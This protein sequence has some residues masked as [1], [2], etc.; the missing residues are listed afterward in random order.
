MGATGL[1][2]HPNFSRLSSFG[3]GGFMTDFKTD[4]PRN[5]YI[6]SGRHS[7]RTILLAVAVFSSAHAADP[8]SIGFTSA[9][10][11]TYGN[12]AVWKIPAPSG[13]QM[14]IKATPGVFAQTQTVTLAWKGFEGTD[15]VFPTPPPGPN[16][17]QLDA[18]GQAIVPIVF[19]KKS[20][21]QWQ[22]TACAK[23]QPPGYDHK[24]D[25]CVYA[26]LEGVDP[27]QINAGKL[28]KIV[29]PAHPGL[30]HNWVKIP[31]HG[32]S[33]GVSVHD[34]ALAKSKDKVVQLVYYSSSTTTQKGNPWP[35][36]VEK[37]S[38]KTLS[39]SDVAGQGGW[40]QKSEPLV[41]DPKMG[42]WLTI[43]ACLNIEYSGKVCSDSYA[44]Q[45][46]KP[47]LKKGSDTNQVIDSSKIPPPLPPQ[48]G[49]GGGGQAGR[50]GNLP[51]GNAGMMAPPPVLGAPAASPPLPATNAHRVQ[52]ASPAMAPAVVPP[53]M[54]SG[55]MAPAA[56]VPGCAVDPAVPGRYA[57]AT[58]EAYAGCERLRGS[59][60][61]GVSACLNRGGRLRR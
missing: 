21:K 25:D 52:P 38:P 37:I 24:I 33:I 32:N 2:P 59:G 48:G 17:V 30:P 43:K 1:R 60:S 22:I 34:D 50:S 13:A 40:V 28:I 47:P 46:T 7:R 58:A 8:V 41:P 51:A 4:E 45:L 27:L 6:L 36:S 14:M 29:S 31:A 35:A 61:A 26:Y 39:L 54:Q 42:E 49:A 55:R 19:D 3:F 12:T 16:S 10:K 20:H 11:T 9:T 57:C 53:A 18:S 23:W 44:Y 15:Q 5:A 56:N